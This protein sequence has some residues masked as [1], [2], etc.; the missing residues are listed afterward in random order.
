MKPL[1]VNP[2]YRALVPRPTKEEYA[3]LE[4]DI[5]EKGEALEPIK[6]NT[7]DEILDGHTRY[8]ICTRHGLFYRTVTMTFNTPLDEMI[9][10]V[11][12][13]LHRR[14]LNGFQRIEM[15][16]SLLP[17]LSK[18]G[19]ENMLAGVTLVQYDT[20]VDTLKTLA[21]HSKLGRV[22]VSKAL[23]I[24]KEADEELK[25]KVRSGEVTINKAN[26]LLKIKEKQRE[27]KESG[28]PPLPEG[29][30]DVIYADP[31]WKYEYGGSLRGKADI[32]YNTMDLKDILLLPIQ[33]HIA[34]DA[35]LLLWTTNTF[36]E[37][38]LKVMRYWGFNYKTCFVWIK[39]RIG[40]GFWLRN[41]HEL[42]LLGVKG[43]FPHPADEDRPSSV[44]QA[45][46][47]EHSAKP[48]LFYPLIEKMYPK[49][50]YLELFAREKREGWTSWGFEA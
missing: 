5:I 12:T 38:S 11:E 4:A 24:M 16:S 41:Q 47:T 39:D 37:D 33:E 40:T 46:Y 35:L 23:K 1:K 9:Y 48:D 43:D 14:H 50:R 17:L 29:F 30:Y 21:E 32:H 2:E 44:I 34:S 26:Q 19:K 22:T 10:V 3:A 42:L 25:E 13:N 45:S 6:I 28:S 7:R 18:K 15:I 20:R 27:I 31:P 49:R 36:L 8:E